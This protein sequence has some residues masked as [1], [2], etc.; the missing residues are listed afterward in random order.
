MTAAMDF[1]AECQVTSLLQLSPL[2][3]VHLSG[4]MVAG[5]GHLRA[6]AVLLQDAHGDAA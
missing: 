4:A 2:Q 5:L 3:A 1:K 6:S